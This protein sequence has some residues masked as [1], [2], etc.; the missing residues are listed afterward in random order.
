MLALA[1]AAACLLHPP[2]ARGAATLRVS[3]DTTFYYDN[4]EYFNRYRAG[5]T[6]L[7]AHASASLMYEQPSFDLSLGA[8]WQRDFG[9]DSEVSKAL[10]LYRLRYKGRHI[11]F[12]TGFIEPRNN[13]GLPDALLVRQYSLLYP[14]EEGM[15]LLANHRNLRIDVW[16]NWFLVNT[17][18][19][20]EFLAAGLHVRA[21]VSHLTGFLGFRVTHHGGQLFD[22]GPVTD[23][24]G[25]MIG[26]TAATDL[27]ALDTQIGASVTLLGSHDNPAQPL[28]DGS[29]GYGIEAEAF[30]VPLGWRF[31]YRVFS[32]WNLRVEQGNPMYRTEKPFHRF[33]VRK[34]F[35][36][37]SEV[38]GR[39]QLE[40]V[41]LDSRLEYSYFLVL[42]VS[43]R[44]LLAT[45]ER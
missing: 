35:P 9:D 15:Q 14:V 44:L 12:I 18:A 2:E 43:L 24:L 11:R 31:Y 23:S 37:G 22:S 25:G 38:W 10:P 3:V 34:H 32:G 33:G 28:P 30:I 40:G 8:F 4:T 39:M 41:V 17:A 26:C 29:L 1:L 42:D 5:A 7:G 36:I 20:R 21:H 19:H 13:H 6:L 45:L 27:P 16:T